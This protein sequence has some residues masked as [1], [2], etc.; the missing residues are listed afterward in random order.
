MGRS[1]MTLEPS[2]PCIYTPGCWMLE[3]DW[4]MGILR[5]AIIFRET[6][7]ECSSRQLLTALH[8]HITSPNDLSYFKGLYSL[9]QQ[10][11]QHWPNKYSK[12][13]GKKDRSF[14]CFCHNYIICIFPAL[15]PSQTHI[16]V[17]T[18][19][20]IHANVVSATLMILAVRCNF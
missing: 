10:K 6:H 13:Q 20:N 7:G 12:Q 2:T 19:V 8:D 4:L 15:S 14:P 5:C 18:H 16:T 11:N 3:S 17:C 9:K 1:I